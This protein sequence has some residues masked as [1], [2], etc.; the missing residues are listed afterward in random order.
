[1]QGDTPSADTVLALESVSRS[2][3]QVKAVRDVSLTL[4]RGEILT[5]LGPSGCGKTT[6]LRIAVGLE[7]SSSGRVTY[8]DRVVDCPADRIFVPPEKRDM[9]MVFQS[10][11]IWPHMNVF[12]NVAFPLRVR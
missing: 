7:R 4:Q 10:Y 11:A 1:M 12:E 9:A 8:R 6:T 5:L 2:Y 3:G